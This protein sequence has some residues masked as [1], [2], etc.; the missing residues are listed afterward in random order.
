MNYEEM[1]E[2]LLELPEDEYY[3]LRDMLKPDMSGLTYKEATDEL[4]RQA[5]RKHGRNMKKITAVCGIS[6]MMYYRT[7]D[8]LFPGQRLK[9]RRKSGPKPLSERIYGPQLLPLVIT[10]QASVGTTEPT[11]TWK[12]YCHSDPIM[13]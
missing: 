4:F 5:I 7:H 2:W 3:A 12:E 6:N 13:E 9:P 10:N 8:R 11:E 1:K